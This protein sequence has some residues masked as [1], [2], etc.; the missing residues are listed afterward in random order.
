[1]NQDIKKMNQGIKKK[2]IE[3]LLSKLYK[4]GYGR[5]H[6]SES[7]EYCCLGVLCELATQEHVC[8]RTEGTRAALY[9][10]ETLLENVPWTHTFYDGETQTLP[11]SVQEWAGLD[12]G[13]PGVLQ[14]ATW[15]T[16]AEL[17]DGG[18][19]FAQL[20]VIIDEQL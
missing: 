3:A 4:R 9:D 14:K 7:D 20:A 1:M 13:N 18:A 16:L 6:D 19:S 8:T 5:L 15:T 2:W 12:S 10:G 11:L 17:N